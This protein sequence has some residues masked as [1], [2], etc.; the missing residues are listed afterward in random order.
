L[1]N[2]LIITGAG[3]FLGQ[4]VMAEAQ[5]RGIAAH[6]VSRQQ[7]PGTQQV[8][9]YA[10]TPSP[11]GATLVHLADAREIAEVAERPG[12]AARAAEIAKALAAK[13]YG[14]V[15]YASSV[16]ALPEAGGGSRSEY[17]EMKR[18]CEAVFARRGAS[19]ARLTNLYGRGDM[20]ASSVIAEIIEKLDDAGPLVV[21]NA[22]AARDFLHVD[23]AA[24]AILALAELRPAGAFSIASGRT[25]TIGEIARLI[26]HAAGQDERDVISRADDP[27]DRIEVDI[28]DTV[29][30]LGW[31]PATTLSDGLASL[32]AG[33]A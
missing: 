24:S 13:P 20:A 10:L 16:A 4:A 27:T 22:A 18:N 17:G 29:E 8:A 30:R 32:F 21:R 12:L 33:R 19:I 26:L 3:G 28:S 31:R 11:N 2:V 6:G 23:D 25:V 14:H 5:R 1:S 9:D 15:V 7:L